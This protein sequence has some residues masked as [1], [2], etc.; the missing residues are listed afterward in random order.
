MEGFLP[1]AECASF[2]LKPVSLQNISILSRTIFDVPAIQTVAA[3]RRG[4]SQE[5]RNFF[6]WRRKWKVERF[7]G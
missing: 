4:N 6:R 1:S 3:V 7:F 5:G 2:A